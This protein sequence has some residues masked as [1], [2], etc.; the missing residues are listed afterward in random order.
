MHQY[1]TVT[2]HSLKLCLLGNLYHQMDKIERISEVSELH[3]QDAS[4]Y[5]NC[6]QNVLAPIWFEINLR[7]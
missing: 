5:Y 1:D 3:G 2:I 7:Y 4:I 6:L